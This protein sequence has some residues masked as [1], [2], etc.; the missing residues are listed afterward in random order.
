MDGHLVVMAQHGFGLDDDVAVYPLERI[1][2]RLLFDDSGE[3]LGR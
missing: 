3:M 2:A 1:N